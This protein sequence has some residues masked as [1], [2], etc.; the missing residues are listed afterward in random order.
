MTKDIKET[1]QKSKEWMHK[2]ALEEGVVNPKTGKPYLTPKCQR[3]LTSVNSNSNTY[4]IQQLKLND[5]IVF[6]EEI[7]LKK[8]RAEVAEE[9]KKAKIGLNN[10]EKKTLVLNFKKSTVDNIITRL[11]KIQEQPFITA[12]RD[13]FLHNAQNYTPHLI[14]KKVKMEVEVVQ[15]VQEVQKQEEG[16]P[17]Y[18]YV[19]VLI[20]MIT[21]WL[22]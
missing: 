14:D 9:W 8:Y 7:F 2:K 21:Y 18:C 1:S 20:F 6:T 17:T 15:E 16:E 19:M 4:L 10:L 22:S 11:K 3:G 5:L 12:K 13:V